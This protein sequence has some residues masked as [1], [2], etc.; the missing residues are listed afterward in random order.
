MKCYKNTNEQFGGDEV[1]E[2]ESRDALVREAE[3]TLRNWA[4]DEYNRTEDTAGIT[5]EDILDRMRREYRDALVE[6]ERCAYCGELVSTD[7]SY[8]NQAGY[9]QH[10]VPNIDDDEAWSA[11]ATEHGAGCEWVTTRAHRLDD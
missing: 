8:I 9:V 11:L 3:S 10:G 2:A 6:V 7:D 5:V 4:Q 1:Q